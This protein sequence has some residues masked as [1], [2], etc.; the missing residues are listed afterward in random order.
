M[1][2]QRG[3]IFQPNLTGLNRNN[4]FAIKSF[5][6]L[7]HSFHELFFQSKDKKPEF[8]CIVQKNGKAKEAKLFNGKKIE[9]IILPLNYFAD[10]TIHSE[11]FPRNGGS[12]AKRT[13]YKNTIFMAI[14]GAGCAPHHDWLA[15]PL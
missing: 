10:Y 1:H 12:N 6:R 4:Y 3:K 15:F 8:V 14:D 7:N 11:K 9:I 13:K 2:S 5:C